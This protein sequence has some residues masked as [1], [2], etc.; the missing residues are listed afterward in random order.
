MVMTRGGARE[1]A[2]CKSGWKKGKT[3]LIRVPEILADQVLDYARK[4]DDDSIIESVTE[5]KVVNLAGIKLK[6]YNGKIAIHI[7]DL[8]KGGYEI[9]PEHLGLMFKS[10]LSQ[11]LGN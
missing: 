8:V 7:E 11:R 5:S 4:L 6:T 9:M 3:K 1:G 10:I 2:G